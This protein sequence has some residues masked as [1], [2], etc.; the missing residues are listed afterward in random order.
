[1]STERAFALPDLGEGLTEAEILAW[2]VA[3]GD[4]VA[5]DQPVVEVETAKASVEVPC[6]Y[7]GTVTRLH[8]AAGDT[9]AVG[10]PLITVAGTASAAAVPRARREAGPESRAEPGAA[11]EQTTV[12]STRKGSDPAG[13]NG[14]AEEHA[15]SGAVLVGYGTGSGA[16]TSRR[17][18][19]GAGGPPRSTMTGGPPPLQDEPPSP[20]PVRVASPLVRRMARE[21]GVDIATVLGSGE[22]GLVLR[23]DVAAAIEARRAPAHRPDPPRTHRTP[24]RGAHRAM[25]EHLERSRREIPEA[26]VWVDADATG[27]VELRRTL[28]G[29]APEHPVSVLALVAR[30]AVAGL[31]VFPELNA[32]FDQERREVVR[33]DDVHLGFAAQ[34]PRGL[35][36]PVVREAQALSTRRLSARLAETAEAARSGALEP[37]A[38]VGGTFTVNNYGVFGVDGSAAIIPPPQ[39]AILGLGRIVRRPWVVG[40]SVVPRPVTELTLAF[41]HRVCD[42]GVAGGFLRYVADRVER[43]DLL[44]GDL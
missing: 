32:H 36:V 18:A 43:P 4:E 3:E 7:G 25:A 26:T 41:D 9:V 30:I 14:A 8:G 31:E 24:L 16:R 19:R 42:G 37:A 10:A 22:G 33:F 29:A 28:N 21:H 12:P 40:E 15:G 5:V 1:M 23:R 11:T 34:T 20:G 38:M 35:V 13:G 39:A 2:L 44:L 17:R 6:P 27:L